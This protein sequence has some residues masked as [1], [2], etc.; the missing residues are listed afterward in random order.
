MAAEIT[1]YRSRLMAGTHDEDFDSD[2]VNGSYSDY[3]GYCPTVPG[4]WWPT[5]RRQLNAL[6][7]VQDPLNPNNWSAALTTYQSDK[8]SAYYMLGHIIH[9]LQDLFVPAHANISP[10]GLGTAG[11]VENHSWPGYFDK[12]E[13]WCE[14][15]ESELS[16]AQA[17]RIPHLCLESLMVRAARFSSTDDN[18]AGF[19]PSDYYAVPETAGGW[20]RY[21]PY[22]SGGYPCGRDRID[23]DLANRWSRHLVPACCEY[24]AAAIRQFYVSANPQ[25]AAEHSPNGIARSMTPPTVNRGS[26]PHH[27]ARVFTPDGRSLTRLVA[28]VYL[29][30]QE[31][32][33]C[34]PIILLR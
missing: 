25:G 16:L 33:K 9:N 26:I 15:T 24:G 14:V 31:S 12:F 2:E 27:N 5:A 3:S 17:S 10:H 21:L 29:L 8:S 28:G 32:G 23:N 7:W 11:L 1:A 4:A 13:Q 30:V 22:P 19:R 18:T 20:G 34:R 6:Q